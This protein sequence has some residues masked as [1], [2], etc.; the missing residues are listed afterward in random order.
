V[1]CWPLFVLFFFIC[2]GCHVERWIRTNQTNNLVQVYF[3]LAKYFQMSTQNAT[4]VFDD[5]QKLKNWIALVVLWTRWCRLL[6][7][8]FVFCEVI[9][10]PLFVLFFC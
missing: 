9:C 2:S 3:C 5:G 7:L 1:I 6:N 10:W 8:S 4:V